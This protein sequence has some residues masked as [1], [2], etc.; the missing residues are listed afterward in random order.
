[1]RAGPAQVS[2]QEAELNNGPEDMQ[3]HMDEDMQMPLNED[4]LPEPAAI[5]PDIDLPDHTAQD[6]FVLEE[7]IEVERYALYTISGALSVN[8]TVHYM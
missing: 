6:I 5:E 7:E 2:I 4:M 3:V 1:M 8:G